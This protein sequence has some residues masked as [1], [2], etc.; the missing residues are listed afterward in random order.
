MLFGIISSTSIQN[1][2]AK[3]NV[4]QSDSGLSFLD[5]NTL[6]TLTSIA[7]H[8]LYTGH[9]GNCSKKDK[10]FLFYEKWCSNLGVC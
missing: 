5:E 8:W 9:F 1:W 6:F 7:L 3:Y 4:A 2:H 10:Y